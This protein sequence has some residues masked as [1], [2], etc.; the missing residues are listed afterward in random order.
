MSIASKIDNFHHVLINFSSYSCYRSI[1][2]PKECIFDA[3]NA[4]YHTFV[5]GQQSMLTSKSNCQ[6]SLQCRK[7]SPE[8]TNLQNTL[9]NIVPNS[10][11]LLSPHPT[12]N[13]SWEVNNS[14]PPHCS[15]CHDEQSLTPSQ[16]LK[17]LIGYGDTNEDH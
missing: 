16:Q 7:D 4:I 11:P 15:P 3:H 13:S 12:L 17:F 9:T 2:H 1:H 6:Q 5:A 14:L 10:Q 8:V